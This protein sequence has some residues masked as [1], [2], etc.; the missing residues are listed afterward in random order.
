MSS[1][2]FQNIVLATDLDGTFLTKDPDGRRRNLEAIAYFKENGGHFTFAT[3]RAHFNVVGEDYFVI[4]EL[5]NLPAAVG[6]GSV[7]YDYATETPVWKANTPRELLL[8]LYAEMKRCS[9]SAVLTPKWEDPL[10]EPDTWREGDFYKL[11][12]RDPEGDLAALIDTLS[13]YFGERLVF[14]RAAEN[15]FDVQAIVYTKAMAL[16]KLCELYFDRPVTLCV[17]GDYHNDLAM[18]RE[19]DLAFC[20][21]NAVDE[22]KAISHATLCHHGEGLMADIV[23]ELERMIDEGAL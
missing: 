10:G 7:L 20:P 8:D 6:N 18:M 3:G 1:Q 12:I 16:R 22:I 14:T 11:D 4:E 23:K 5:L 13:K 15:C 21:E 2:K 17:A 9:P 19:A